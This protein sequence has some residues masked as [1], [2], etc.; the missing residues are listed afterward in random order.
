MRS[1]ALLS[2]VSL[3]LLI[4]VPAQAEIL[5]MMKHESKPAEGL[6]LLK[7]SGDQVRREGIAIIDVDPN[8]ADFG[9]I[10]ADIPLD[11]T[12]V[13]HHIFYDRSMTKAYVTSIKQPALQV[14]DMTQNPYRIKMI[15]VPNCQFAEEVSFDEANERWYLTC[16]ASA[17]VYV[18]KIAD[19]S[20]VGAIALP[21]TYPHGLAAKT[22]IDRVLVSS[23][24]TPDLSPQPRRSRW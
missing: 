13:A 10:L 19:D 23:T 3:G 15:E 11:S 21:G 7:L 16:M 8:S 5:A 14:I 20:L 17:N 6:K 2:L 9:K 1:V 24:I 22:A 12:A 18:G 4:T